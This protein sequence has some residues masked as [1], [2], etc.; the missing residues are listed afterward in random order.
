MILAYR[1]FT[2]ILYP[3]LILF[4]YFRVLIKKEDPIRYKEKIL[5]KFF[6][7]KSLNKTKLI[8]FHAASIGEFKSIIPLIEKMNT[9][10]N[11]FEYLITTNTLSS[12]NIAKIELKRFKNVQH[13]FMPLD[14]NHLIKKF[15]KTWKPERIFLVDSEIWPNLIISAKQY[16]L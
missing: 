16:K 15:L 11:I 14:V 13:R 8:W 5:V 10:Y 2:N 9:K 4:I 3:F 12:G 6:N 1:I 7:Y